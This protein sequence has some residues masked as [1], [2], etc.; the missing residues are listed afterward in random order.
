MLAPRPGK[1]P[2]MALATDGPGKS[3][4]RWSGGTG[5]MGAT[6]SNGDAGLG[7][8]CWVC[9]GKVNFGVSLAAIS[10]LGGSGRGVCGE[11]LGGGGGGA[12]GLR[13]AAAWGSGD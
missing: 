3:K 1:L 5:V 2:R 6:S 11:A 9:T 7:G 10:T 4:M 12:K 13:G 8:A